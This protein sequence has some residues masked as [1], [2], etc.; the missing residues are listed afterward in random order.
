MGHALPDEPSVASDAG[1]P[2]IETLPAAENAA[3]DI[4][5]TEP[6]PVIRNLME[7]LFPATPPEPRNPR[8]IRRFDY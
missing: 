7:V 3:A 1:L 8:V 6:M 2:R 5:E 4:E